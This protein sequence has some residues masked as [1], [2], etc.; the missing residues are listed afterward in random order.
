MVDKLDKGY[1]NTVD[2]EKF[3]SSFGVTVPYD[4]LHLIISRY[5]H[6]KDVIKLTP[7]C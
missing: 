5:S 3:L 6:G 2:L 4:E 7:F 1:V